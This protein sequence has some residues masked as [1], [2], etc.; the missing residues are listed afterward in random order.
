MVEDVSK[1]IKKWNTPVRTTSIGDT[2]CISSDELKQTLELLNKYLSVPIAQA[3][4]NLDTK[5]H[6]EALS[7]FLL[8][9]IQ[10]KDKNKWMMLGVFIKSI[11][12]TAL[13]LSQAKRTSEQADKLLLDHKLKLTEVQISTSDCEHQ[14]G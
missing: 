14:A 8:P 11:D 7:S 4:L 2:S 12:T 1:I 9:H 3:I 10:K 6:F 5:Q 13:Q